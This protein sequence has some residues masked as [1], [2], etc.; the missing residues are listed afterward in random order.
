M[1]EGEVTNAKF[2][3]VKAVR[4]WL[5]AEKL[6]GVK[7]VGDPALLMPILLPKDLSGAVDIGFIPHWSEYEDFSNGILSKMSKEIKSNSLLIN[8]KTSDIEGTIEQICKCKFILSSS[9]HGIILAHAYGIPALWIRNTDC[10][11]D[12]FKYYDYFSSVNIRRYD[13]FKNFE[14]GL[15]DLNS[16]YKLFDDNRTISLPQ[17]NIIADIQKQLIDAFPFG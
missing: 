12:G 9:L 15:T 10:D 5:S 7:T 17:P 3:N 14:N 8:F 2:N 6:G 4:G 13:G 1:N 11:T 16:V